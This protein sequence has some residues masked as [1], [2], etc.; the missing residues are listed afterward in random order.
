MAENLSRS[1]GDA[2]FNAAAL[3]KAI[4]TVNA[5]KAKATEMNGEAGALT[6]NAVEEHNFEKTAFTFVS[7]LARKED[8]DAQAIVAA[9]VT[10]AHALGMFD[11]SDLFQDHTKAMRAVLDKIDAGKAGSGAATVRN[12]AKNQTDSGATAH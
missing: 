8:A 5:A 6:K 7:R 3:K 11:T 2:S 4:K 1:S 9:V 10:Y 12:L